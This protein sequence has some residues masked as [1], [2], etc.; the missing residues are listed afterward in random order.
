MLEF[1]SVRELALS[2][3]TVRLAVPQ[4]TTFTTNPGRTLLVIVDME[5]EFCHPSG[6]LYLGEEAESAVTATQ[7]LLDEARNA[8]CRVLW[9]RS[10]RDEDAIEFRAFG[11][12]PHLMSGSWSVEF[13][14]PLRP[15]AM[16]D[17]VEKRS[18][19]CFNQ[20]LLDETLRAR[21]LEPPDSILVAGVAT[22][23]CVSHAVLGF[24]VRGYRVAVLVDAVA[25]RSG[26]AA[27]A[28]LWRFGTPG[29]SYNVHITTTQ[30]VAFERGR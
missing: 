7:S 8:G 24:S 13:R 28:T 3:E 11:V 2:V 10:V 1:D 5:N 4:A 9:V 15:L 16:E 18:H 21:G 19:D 14:S 30:Q 22:D 12:A 23:V 25:P 27:A 20:T 17:I 26:P 6:A 29:Y